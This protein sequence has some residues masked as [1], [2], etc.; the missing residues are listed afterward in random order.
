MLS[1]RS[2]TCNFLNQL[3]QDNTHSTSHRRAFLPGSFS[4][5]DRKQ[6]R[7]GGSAGQLSVF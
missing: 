5:G 7:R 2:R 1:F 6:G 3:N 4:I